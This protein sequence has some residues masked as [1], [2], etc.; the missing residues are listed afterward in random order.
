MTSSPLICTLQDLNFTMKR[1][2]HAF[3]VRCTQDRRNA[4]GHVPLCA[5]I[6][7]YIF[8]KKTIFCDKRLSLL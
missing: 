3:N 6:I 7:T 4:S 1:D 8:Y 2:Q 5:N